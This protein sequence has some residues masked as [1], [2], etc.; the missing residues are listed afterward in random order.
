MVDASLSHRSD[1]RPLVK[2]RRSFPSGRPSGGQRTV[3]TEAP[4]TENNVRLFP[5]RKHRSGTTGMKDALF[6]RETA[7]CIVQTAD[8]TLPVEGSNF[9]RPR[10]KPNS[11][12]FTFDLGGYRASTWRGSSA[13]LVNVSRDSCRGT[14]SF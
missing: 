14:S 10:Q 7:P 12:I 1:S 3:R 5:C 11:S 4:R 2:S 8:E 6:R 9:A 13:S